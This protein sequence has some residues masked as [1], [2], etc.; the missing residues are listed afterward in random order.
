MGKNICSS[1]SSIV[2]R[3]YYELWLSYQTSSIYWKKHSYQRAL[4][5]CKSTRYYH[6]DI[7]RIMN[8]E[9]IWRKTS[10]KTRKKLFFAVLLPEGEEWRLSSGGHAWRQTEE[11]GGLWRGRWQEAPGSLYKYPLY[12]IIIFIFYYL[13][14]SLELEIRDYDD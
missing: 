12:S 11:G 3:M 4:Q 8:R 13:K 5:V 9:R 1:W 14:F 7:Q 2:S 10:G 6:C